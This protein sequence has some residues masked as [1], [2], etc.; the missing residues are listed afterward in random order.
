MN[1]LREDQSVVPVLIG[2]PHTAVPLRFNANL[3]QAA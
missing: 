2:L 1:R 3:L